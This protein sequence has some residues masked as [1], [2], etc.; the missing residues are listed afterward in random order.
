MPQFSVFC[1]SHRRLIL[2]VCILLRHQEKIR[3]FYSVNVRRHPSSIGRTIFLSLAK[4]WLIE[5]CQ[6]CQADHLL[7]SHFWQWP[8]PREDLMIKESLGKHLTF[9][10]ACGHNS[11]NCIS[12]YFF[13]SMKVEKFK[14][15]HLPTH[16]A[17]NFSSKAYR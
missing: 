15:K 3:N 7:T 11:T 4:S 10:M 5:L 8:L 17:Q 1:L 6:T 16:P 2:E 13:L 14:N 9:S 12:K